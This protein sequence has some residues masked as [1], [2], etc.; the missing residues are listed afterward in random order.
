MKKIFGCFLITIFFAGMLFTGCSN[1]KQSTDNNSAANNSTTRTIVDMAGRKVTIPKKVKKVFSVSPVGTIIVYSLAPGKVAGWNYQLTDN[2]KKYILKQYRE[3]PNL[4][5]M[6]GNG[7]SGSMEQIL[8]VHPDI[9]ISMGE[10]GKADISSAEKLQKQLNIPVILVDGS[11]EKLDKAYKIIGEAIGED[12]KA[13]ELGDYCKKSISDIKAMTKKIPE[14]KKV[15]VYY[16]EGLDGLQTDPKGSSHTEVLD[17]VKGNNVAGAELA[18]GNASPTVS[19]EQVVA[20]DPEVIIVGFKAGHEGGTYKTITTDSKWQN[21]KAVK[22]QKVYNI[23]QYPF[24]WFDRP[25]SVNRIIGLKWLGNLLY[26]DYV[27][28][29]IKDEVKKFYSKFYHY[30]LTDDEAAKMLGNK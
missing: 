11:L 18:K 13:K 27:K 19:M 26:P 22:E 3:L 12:K 24:N 28:V 21:I 30:N 17:L 15:N 1:T 10:M 9:I 20:W 16:A 6:S 5:T 14:D 4:G 29:N 25:P 2:E 7:D 8:K 23:P